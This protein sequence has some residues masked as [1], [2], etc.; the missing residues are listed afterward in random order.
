VSVNGDKDI[1]LK[2]SQHVLNYNRHVCNL[3][4]HLPLCS[5]APLQTPTLMS[6]TH[7]HS[8]TCCWRRWVRDHLHTHT[9]SGTHTRLLFKL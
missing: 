2:T 3:P 4:P 5:L 7:T 1:R 6:R 8:H 9:N